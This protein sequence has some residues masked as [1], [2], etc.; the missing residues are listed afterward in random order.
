MVFMLHWHVR[1]SQ[2]KVHFTILYTELIWTC[3]NASQ[4]PPT[5]KTVHQEKSCCSPR[6][7]WRRVPTGRRVCFP[8]CTYHIT[9]NMFLYFRKF[10]S[11]EKPSGFGCC[12]IMKYDLHTSR[13]Y[14]DIIVIVAEEEHVTG[15]N[16]KQA[17]SCVN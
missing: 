12:Q 17:E 11:T 6:Q 8:V 4:C 16:L 14:D 10:L 1:S 13:V 5:K 7:T 2:R 15:K 9:C 3:I